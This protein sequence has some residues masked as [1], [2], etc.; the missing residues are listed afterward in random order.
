MLVRFESGETAEIVEGDPVAAGWLASG[1][2]VEV[3]AEEQ[4]AAAEVKE[5]PEKPAPARQR[6]KAAARKPETR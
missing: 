3:T 1:R 4:A 5:T 6:G 2:C